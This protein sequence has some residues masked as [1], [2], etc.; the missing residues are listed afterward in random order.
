MKN[1][2]QYFQDQNE[3]PDQ[4]IP[5]NST[6][7]NQPQTKVFSPPAVEHFIAQDRKIK[8]METEIEVKKKEIEEF[9]KKLQKITDDHDEMTKHMIKSQ[10]QKEEVLERF[11]PTFKDVQQIILQ[12]VL[13]TEYEDFV[14]T[15]VLLREMAKDEIQ[16]LGMAFSVDLFKEEPHR[17]QNCQCEKGFLI[18]KASFELSSWIDQEIKGVAL[19]FEKLMKFGMIGRIVLT[20]SKQ[21]KF[22]QKHWKLSYLLTK[23]FK[24][25]KFPAVINLAITSIPPSYNEGYIEDAR[26]R[27]TVEVF[28]KSVPYQTHLPIGAF[29]EELQQFDTS[30]AEQISLWR[31]FTFINSGQ[32]YYHPLAL[33]DA[34]MKVYARKEV[35]PIDIP[36]PNLKFNNPSMVQ[37][38]KDVNAIIALSH[39]G[40]YSTGYLPVVEEEDELPLGFPRGYNSEYDSDQSPQSDEMTL[41]TLTVN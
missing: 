35:L 34:T 25:T 37:H 6:T 5:Y 29:K 1:L 12:K 14:Q 8:M 39:M 10:K 7:K 18:V 19:S 2:S 26:H 21:V 24:K 22:F 3:K 13:K 33:E 16:P 4:I 17:H 28:S 15:Q 41:S 40:D 23:I 20:K 31:A 11:P 36:F 32:S 30:V 27:I 38:F 9:Q